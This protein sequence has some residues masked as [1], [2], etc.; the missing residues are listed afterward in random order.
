MTS[1]KAAAL[2]R[3]PLLEGIKRVKAVTEEEGPQLP[4]RYRGRIPFHRSFTAHGRC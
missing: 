3:T 2:R 1:R 4:K